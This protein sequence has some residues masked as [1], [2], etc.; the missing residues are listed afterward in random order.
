[1]Y[2]KHAIR[3]NPHAD[4]EWCYMCQEWYRNLESQ[5]SFWFWEEHCK[6]HFDSLFTRFSERYSGSVDNMKGISIVDGKFVEF[7]LGEGFA[8]SRPEFH[9]HMVKR[10]TLSPCFCPFCIFDETL[11]FAERVHQ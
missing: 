5:G 9:G 2:D 10:V 3:L 1:M 6:A 8:G 7:E 4:I 11:E